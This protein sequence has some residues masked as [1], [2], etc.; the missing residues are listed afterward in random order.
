MLLPVNTMLNDCTLPNIQQCYYG[1]P[2]AKITNEISFIYTKSLEQQHL[3]CKIISKAIN[4][5]TKVHLVLH[6]VLRDNVSLSVVPIWIQIHEKQQ[7]KNTKGLKDQ[8][9]CPTACS[10]TKV[11]LLDKACLKREKNSITRPR[12]P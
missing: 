11:L 8:Q 1:L 6:G 2:M 3:C 5:Q 12:Q 4:K 9:S 7:G 10:R